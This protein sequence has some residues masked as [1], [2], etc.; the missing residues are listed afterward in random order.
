MLNDFWISVQ[1]TI[2]PLHTAA[3]PN[4]GIKLITLALINYLNY[5]RAYCLSPQQINNTENV[6]KTRSTNTLWHLSLFMNWII[7]WSTI[8]DLPISFNN[9]SH[10]KC[11]E[12]RH[13]PCKRTNTITLFSLLPPDRLII[14]RLE[15]SHSAIPNSSTSLPHTSCYTGPEYDC[16]WKSDPNK[17][18]VN[19]IGKLMT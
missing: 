5:F 12:F 10:S 16:T 13:A 18:G 8:H 6:R 2:I 15:L 7:P 11:L 14:H 9:I 3:N 1:K 4:N 19:T 17:K